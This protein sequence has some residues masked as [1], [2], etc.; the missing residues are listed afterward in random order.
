MVLLLFLPFMFRFCDPF[1]TLSSTPIPC[2]IP[3][4][5]LSTCDSCYAPYYGSWYLMTH[6]SFHPYCS[7][8][9]LWLTSFSICHAFPSMTH[10]HHN[11]HHVIGLHWCFNTALDTAFVNGQL[12]DPWLAGAFSTNAT[13]LWVIIGWTFVYKPLCTYPKVKSSFT[14]T[15]QVSLKSLSLRPVK[16]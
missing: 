12:Q 6:F 10:L 4:F 16:D 7:L 1:I 13:L 14:L 15:P 9:F 2:P 11:S 5:L 3:F 8:C